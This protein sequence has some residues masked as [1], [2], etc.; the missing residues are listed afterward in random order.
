MLS[1]YRTYASLHCRPDRSPT[2]AAWAASCVVDIFEHVLHLQY[3]HA[4]AGVTGDRLLAPNTS[5]LLGENRSRVSEDILQRFIKVKAS[6]PVQ[7]R[8][9]HQQLK[10]SHRKLAAGLR[11][12]SALGRKAA[13]ALD[14][15]KRLH[16]VIFKSL[17][18]LG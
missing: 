1:T 10:A 7:Q 11:T 9:L 13:F 16:D 4:P 18:R 3:I 8:E 14:G 2:R 6:L 12:D 17:Y 5:Q 15:R